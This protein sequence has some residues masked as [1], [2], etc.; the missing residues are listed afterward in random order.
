MAGAVGALE[1]DP[2]DQSLVQ[3]R[4]ESKLGMLDCVRCCREWLSQYR[5]LSVTSSRGWTGLPIPRSTM[6]EPRTAAVE[7]RHPA[8]GPEPLEPRIL[9]CYDQSNL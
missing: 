3:G 8:P 5:K 1:G 6:D 7:H 9:R 2:A 4:F